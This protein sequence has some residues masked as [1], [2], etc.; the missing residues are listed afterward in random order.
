M[1]GDLTRRLGVT[2]MVILV[3]GISTA[4]PFRGA[5]AGPP[6]PEPAPTFSLRLLDGK[7]L[8]SKALR[9]HPVV[10]RFLASW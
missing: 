6:P 2:V 1:L 7:V 4:L 10:L 3:V 9:G 5:W 8:S